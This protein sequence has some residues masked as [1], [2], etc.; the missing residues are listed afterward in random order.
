M[1]S[2]F[3]E[4][5]GGSGGRSE[6]GPP[7]SQIFIPQVVVSCTRNAHFPRKLLQDSPQLSEPG[8][9]RRQVYFGN[10]RFVH[11]K[12]LLLP[13][14]IG[15]HVPLIS[16]MPAAAQIFFFGS[17]LASPWL[18]R[19]GWQKL[20]KTPRVFNNYLRNRRKHKVFVL[21][22]SAWI[23]LKSAWQQKSNKN[24]C[25]FKTFSC[26]AVLAGGLRS[27]PADP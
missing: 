24:Q 16:K 7:S 17:C 18:G 1:A 26:V 27:A 10:G 15:K 11:A 9:S 23:S 6:V 5:L 22:G 19:S 8:P 20:Q 14:L 13:K 4:L 2:I 12:R 3:I 25:F 21:L